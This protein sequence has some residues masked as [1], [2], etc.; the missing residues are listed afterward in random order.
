MKLSELRASFK[1][2]ANLFPETDPDIYV[3]RDE[4]DTKIK[5]VVFDATTGDIRIESE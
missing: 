4:Y 1:R 2:L 3:S 5:A